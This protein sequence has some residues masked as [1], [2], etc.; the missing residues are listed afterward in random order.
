MANTRQYD[1][2]IRDTSRKLQAVRRGETWPLTASERARYAGYVGVAFAK[3]T[4]LKESPMAE[5]GMD[6]VFEDAIARLQAELQAAEMGK[7]AV[8]AEEAKAKVAKKASGWW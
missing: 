5:R 6:R 7:A 8:I 3:A 1:R 2:I 4:R